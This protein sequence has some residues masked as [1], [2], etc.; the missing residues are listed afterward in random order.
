MHLPSKLAITGSHICVQTKIALLQ[1]QD[2]AAIIG[3]RASDIS[4]S[5][6]TW[7]P[8]HSS[9]GLAPLIPIPNS[10]GIGILLNFWTDAGQSFTK[11]VWKGIWHEIFDFSFFTNQ[12]SPRPWVT[13]KDRFNFSRKFA[14]IIANQ[15][16]SAG[17]TTPAINCLVVPTT[18]LANLSPVS[19][20]PAINLC[21]WFSVMGGGSFRGGS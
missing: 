12:C 14:E 21:H 13:H 16:L 5:A 18:L 4:I 8:E 7:S 20:T 10:F 15:C 19:P 6:C 3:I 9:N 17:S 11:T 1:P 2:D